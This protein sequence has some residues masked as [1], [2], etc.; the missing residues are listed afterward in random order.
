MK[1]NIQYLIDISGKSNEIKLK[2]ACLVSSKR[3][4]RL[5]QCKLLFNFNIAMVTKRFYCTQTAVIEFVC[6]TLIVRICNPH[7]VWKTNLTFEKQC[8]PSGF[9]LEITDVIRYYK[10]SY[11]IIVMDQLIS[12]WWMN[13]HSFNWIIHDCVDSGLRLVLRTQYRM[14]VYNTVG[15]I[16]HCFYY[17]TKVSNVDNVNL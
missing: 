10:S 7:D 4:K 3:P 11:L 12:Y 14:Y 5:Q 15:E 6:I 17:C 9:G 13:D 8:V 1:R 2:N 16:H